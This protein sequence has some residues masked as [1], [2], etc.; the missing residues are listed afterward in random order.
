MHLF[1]HYVL[2]EITTSD[3]PGRGAG[4]PIIFSMI[5]LHTKAMS[6][7]S[8]VRTEL[9]QLPVIPSLAPHPVQT[10]CESS[11]HGD[12]GDLSSSP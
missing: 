5:L 9:G 8:R 11:R 6:G 10:H 3:S 12:F 4:Y 1:G 2:L 7:L